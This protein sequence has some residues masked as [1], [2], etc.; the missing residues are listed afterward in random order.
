MKLS[1]LHKTLLFSVLFHALV[2][3]LFALFLPSQVTSF[4]R[5]PVELLPL[6]RPPDIIGAKP[7]ALPAAE[8]V[9]ASSRPVRIYLPD[10]PPETVS[11]AVSFQAGAPPEVR[12]DL[13]G[14][15]SAPGPVTLLL[16]GPGGVPGAARGTGGAIALL[17]PGRERRP[18]H[19]PL[20][21][22][23]AWAEQRGVEA[24][25]ELRLWIDPAGRVSEV[26]VHT[27]SGYPEIDRLCLDTVG[28]WQFE[29]GG[30]AA[31][32]AILP[33]RFQLR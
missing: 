18:R 19:A 21:V 26:A 1:L 25:L 11:G 20:P 28:G 10:A 3:A 32:W 8:R 27:T 33:L 6:P 7:A 16:P 9:E 12:Y 23:P 31:T 17:G 29:P 15:A 4:T 24:Y 13:S 2:L 22:Y 30:E 14:P 5:I